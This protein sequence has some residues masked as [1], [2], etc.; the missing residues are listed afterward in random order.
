[1]AVSD[2]KN[3]ITST[4]DE[5]APH[6]VNH[7][8]DSNVL[9]SK[10]LPKAKM[11]VGETH[12]EP[13][14]YKS[15][16]AGRSFQGADTLGTSV[17]D[18][19]V[20]MQFTPTNYDMHVSLPVDQIMYN[21]GKAQVVD[22]VKRQMQTR[23][24]QMADELGDI[25]YGDGTGNNGKDFDGLESLVDDG[26]NVST[27]GGLSRST[28]STLNSTVTDTSGTLTLL[29]MRNLWNSVSSGRVTPTDSFTTE[30]I[31]SLY[32]SLLDPQRRIMVS[33]DGKQ[34][35]G[36]FGFDTLSFEGKPI[37]K[38]EKC[39]SGTMYFLNMDFLEF[40]AK[41]W[42]GDLM[43]AKYKEVNIAGDIVKDNQYSEGVKGLGF[44]MTEFIQPFNA[45]VLISH[46]VLSGN[47]ITSNPR[48]HGKL[49][50]ITGV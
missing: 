39:P 27:I 40:R 41:P 6:V 37:Y 7:V 35:N 2:Q 48:R 47:M 20:N 16:P 25:F 42:K 50:G 18:N 31:Y 3:V 46:I 14:M 15:G 43:G 9:L 38:D 24:M 22:L 49:T 11:W 32:E 1:M 29:K 13:I 28:Y 44:S 23:A 21:K 19:F 34:Q 12:K 33:G 36:G 5:I 17:A 10:V 4:Q 45:H 30:A 26:T 8:F